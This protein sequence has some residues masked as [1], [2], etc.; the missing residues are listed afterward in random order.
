[1]LGFALH[2]HF[3]EHQDEHPA[4]EN[5]NETILTPKWMKGLLREVGARKRGEKAARRAIRFLIESGV[6]EDTGRTMKP[7]RS[8]QA[9]ARAEKF[10]KR[11]GQRAPSSA[12]TDG[13][14]TRVFTP[15]GGGSSASLLGSS[16]VPS[17]PSWEKRLPET[18]G[19]CR[20]GRF[21]KRRFPARA[22]ARA[23]IRAPFGGLSRTRG[24]H[25]RPSLA[26]EN[27]SRG[28]RTE[29]TCDLYGVASRAE[30][31]LAASLSR[32]GVL[33]GR[34]AGGSESR[35]ALDRAPVFQ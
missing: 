24:H 30:H 17:Q 4:Y 28:P 8:A 29:S 27:D 22:G 18:N 19:L 7:K 25:E 21:V 15:T 33:R 2:L 14:R 6:I 5:G 31:V 34:I 9:I 10:Q 1:M 16:P 11:Q 26:G 12:P 32:C 35:I 20:H 3:R 13:G 23:L